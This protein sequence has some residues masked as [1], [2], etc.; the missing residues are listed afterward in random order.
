MN[1]NSCTF[2]KSLSQSS[3]LAELDKPVFAF[4]GRSNSGKSSLLNT[5]SAQRNLARVGKTPGVTKTVNLFLTNKKFYLADLPGYG[6]A[7]MS[8]HDRKELQE[9]I[10]WFLENP[11]NQLK[12]LFVLIDCKAGPT[13]LDIEFLDY[14]GEK[15]IPTTIIASKVDKLKNSERVRHLRIINQFAKNLQV[16]PFSIHTE[17]GKQDIIRELLS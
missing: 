12:Q 13:P 8:K 9:L 16:I 3:N 17:E 15:Q 1:F 11:D 7:K 2:Y 5:I 10:F 4:I 14:V 6:F